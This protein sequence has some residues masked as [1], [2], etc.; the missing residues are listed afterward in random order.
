MINLKQDPLKLYFYLSKICVADNLSLSSCSG[1]STLSE[2]LFGYS[3]IH[4]LRNK[5]YWKYMNFQPEIIET[6]KCVTFAVH[7]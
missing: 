1:Q 7:L 4:K 5:I 6:S 2:I 3:G